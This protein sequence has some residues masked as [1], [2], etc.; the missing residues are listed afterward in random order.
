ML[1]SCANAWLQSFHQRYKQPKGYVLCNAVAVQLVL[2]NP[3]HP[4]RC[5]KAFNLCN[6]SAQ[7]NTFLLATCCYRSDQAHRAYHLLVGEL[8]NSSVTLRQPATGSC[9]LVLHSI[10]C[11]LAIAH[12]LQMPC[13]SQSTLTQQ[14]FCSVACKRRRDL[15]WCTSLQAANMYR[16]DGCWHSAA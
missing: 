6:C 1:G 14:A 7:A 8:P 3:G 4:S 12:S 10:H 13:S 9:C 5:S 11:P 16:V 15:M 2:H